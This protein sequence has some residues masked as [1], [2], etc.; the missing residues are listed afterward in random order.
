M[1]SVAVGKA[2]SSTK[3]NV[4][5]S[6]SSSRSTK[7]SKGKTSKVPSEDT[8]DHNDD[9]E[10]DSVGYNRTHINSQTGHIVLDDDDEDD[11]M[12]LYS[13]DKAARA[14]RQPAPPKSTSKTKVSTKNTKKVL[15]IKKD[16][17][18][19]FHDETSAQRSKK[20]ATSQKSK[21]KSTKA[22]V[23]SKT[24]RPKPKRPAALIES[25]D[26]EVD[27]Q[28]SS[29]TLPP[30]SAQGVS[31]PEE[32]IETVLQNYDLE[33]TRR[34]QRFRDHLN[35]IIDGA[36]SQMLTL[37]SSWPQSTRNMG[38]RDFTEKYGADI[39]RAT[40][41]FAAIA[42]EARNDTREWE[43]M[44]RKRQREK[45]EEEEE[46]DQQRQAKASKSARRTKRTAPASKAG[47]SK[48]AVSRVASSS[49]SSSNSRARTRSTVAPSRSTKF[50]TTSRDVAPPVLSSGTNA[51][52]ADTFSPQI[53]L[54]S[55]TATLHV[56]TP[57]KPAAAGR[58]SRLPKVG[59]VIQ[60]Y[61]LNGSP[62][63]AVVGADGRL[64]FPA[65]TEEA[66]KDE[67]EQQQPAG[68]STS[69]VVD[70]PTG[71]QSRLQ[72]AS[73][74]PQRNS[75]YGFG[76]TTATYEDDTKARRKDHALQS[77][78]VA[79]DSN[80]LPDEAAYMRQIMAEET[81]RRQAAA[82]AQAAAS[83][84]LSA[85][86]TSYQPRSS[87]NN[88]TPA[89]SDPSRPPSSGGT[90]AGGSRLLGQSKSSFSR[91][92]GA[93]QHHPR[94][95][96]TSSSSPAPSSPTRSHTSVHHA[97]SSPSRPTL[98]S[99]IPSSSSPSRGLSLRLSPTRQQQQQ[100]QHRSPTG[101][102]SAPPT[103]TGKRLSILNS[104]GEAVDLA[105]VQEEDIPT[106][107]KANLWKLFGRLGLGG[108]ASTRSSPPRQR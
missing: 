41:G 6:S 47:S 32:Q 69:A 95:D 13:P 106:D 34:A 52:S 9:D 33:A 90:A 51:P 49:S 76:V 107:Q 77:S 72:P 60:Y 108:G 84:A 35:L 28:T 65:A 39:D 89:G 64:T 17:N 57:R 83:T 7:I 66:Q 81:A 40:Q 23:S 12:A 88:A 4:A 38:L 48:A 68:P 14:A 104:K 61:S 58:P 54:P 93:L 70:P 53:D 55:S 8:F 42:N 73:P 16:V 103:T 96:A 45:D 92:R 20:P 62:I 97:P 21:A 29:F 22:K 99:G 18:A 105:N 19:S 63:T 71:R 80:E 2:K 98:R 10:D 5:A 37:L 31:M 50:S 79:D 94:S 59:E 67:Y 86:R 82:A 87:H 85:G 78:D 101:K 100:Q 36:R 25:S 1:S 75:G 56:Q 102:S 44:K 27:P 30:R 26:D 43:D 46:A 74:A 24:S 15:G 91:L 11:E 3:A